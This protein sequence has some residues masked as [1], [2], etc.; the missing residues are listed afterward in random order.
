LK[1]VG[2]Q[3]KQEI[4]RRNGGWGVFSETNSCILRYSRQVE[5]TAHKF[6][7]QQRDYEDLKEELVQQGYVGLLEA[8]EKFESSKN[9]NGFWSYA[10]SFVKGRMK[11]FILYNRAPIRPSR[12]LN[13]LVLKIYKENLLHNTPEHISDYLG[14][15]IDMVIQGLEYM[16]IRNVRS[17]NQ[18]LSQDDNHET[19]ELID[20]IGDEEER[21]ALFQVEVL[22]DLSEIE[23]GIIEMLIDRYSAGD[24]I[25]HYKISKQALNN[26]LQKIVSSCGYDC[27]AILNRNEGWLMG[28]DQI[29]LDDGEEK[30]RSQLKWVQLEWV[31][32]N[33]KNPRLDLNVNTEYLQSLIE[34]IGWEEPLTCYRSGDYFIIISGHRRWH[35]AIQLKQTMIP[36]FIVEAPKNE[37]EELDRIGSVQGGQVEWSQYDQ[38]KYTYDRWIASGKKSFDSLGDELGISRSMTGSRIRVYKYYPK[39]EIEDKLNNRM[40]SI[41]MLDYIHTWIKRLAKNHP[42]FVRSLGEHYIRRLMLKK[43]EA[44]CFN[45]QIGQDHRFV[46][47]A[48]PQSIREFLMDVNKKLQNYQIQS[49][50]I[51]DDKIDFSSIVYEIKDLQAKT[52]E[53]AKVLLMEVEGLLMS[54]EQKREQLESYL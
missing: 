14:C 54:V 39:D 45:S 32:P 18:P 26:I 38:V 25:R 4:K 47:N 43:Y 22:G 23:Q 28:L 29:D 34:S 40:Y 9:N 2:S 17:L 53:E 15:T 27:T 24:I 21:D 48:T 8:H 44:R 37:A 36:V 6:I 13:S 33:P 12:R 10:C 31:L 42:D 20:L 11:D 35:A 41:S 5:R 50:Y 19:L 30:A 49:V 52:K 3:R 1:V 7:R 16:K 46:T 51:K